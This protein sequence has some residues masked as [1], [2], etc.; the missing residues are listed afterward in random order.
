MFLD[1]RLLW[2]GSGIE[3]HHLFR[4]IQCFSK[5]NRCHLQGYRQRVLYK[6]AQS[7]NLFI[8]VSKH[9]R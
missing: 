8:S 6:L 1:L 9:H 3:P 2:V 4:S 7:V 5:I